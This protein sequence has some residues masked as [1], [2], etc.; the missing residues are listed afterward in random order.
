MT[1]FDD[2]EKYIESWKMDLD[3]YIR[4]GEPGRAERSAAWKAA[5]GLQAVD[6]LKTS[7]YLLETAKQH[8][9]GAISITDAQRRIESYYESHSARQETEQADRE[10]DIVSSRITALLQE[11]AFQFSPV[12]LKQ[13]HRRLFEGTFDHAGKYRTY[14]IS[15][16]EWI[17]NDKSVFYASADSLEATL[18]FDFE[19]ESAFS[20]KRL[21][22]DRTIKHIAKFTAGVWQI[23]P[24][25]EGNTRTTAVFIVK[26]LRTLGFEPDHTAFAEN[27]WYF[28]NALVRANY[29]DVQNGVHQT[30]V[31]LERFFENLL[32]GAHRELKNRFMHIDYDESKWQ[33]TPSAATDQDTDQDTDQVA[34]L[35][36]VMDDEA[37][38]ANELMAL[39][40]IKHRPTFRVNYL[41]PALEA[42]VI[43]RTIPDKPRSG[44][45]KYRKTRR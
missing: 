11:Q 26:Y 1:N 9:E 33:T 14:N 21:S 25:G 28:R 13:I 37:Y 24:F 27:S 2:N 36:S 38:S 10:A 5:I 16:R 34:K 22:M 23:H 35:L 4:Q 15:K 20:Y 18:A 6:G 32:A 45:Q 29:N 19:Q 39:I 12:E 17:L 43:E 30:N 3:E 42:G 7:D 31:F 41:N 40:G 44:N 8:I